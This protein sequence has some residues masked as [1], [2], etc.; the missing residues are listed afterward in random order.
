MRM[1]GFA[2]PD[3]QQLTR[4]A[5]W[6]K[7]SHRPAKQDEARCRIKALLTPVSG[8]SSVE[9]CQS[10]RCNLMID[11]WWDDIFTITTTTMTTS[12]V[13]QIIPMSES[14]PWGSDPLLQIANMPSPCTCR[15]RILIV[16]VKPSLTQVSNACIPSYMRGYFGSGKGKG[17]VACDAGFTGHIWRGS[18]KVFV[19]VRSR[20]NRISQGA[21]LISFATQHI[22]FSVYMNSKCRGSWSF[23]Y[24]HVVLVLAGVFCWP[25]HRY[26]HSVTSC[27]TKSRQSI[28]KL[29]PF[30]STGVFSLARFY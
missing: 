9:P 2:T 29:F 18:Q 1:D 27:R 26:Q 19:L 7:I 21:G 25:R 24:L 8:I 15:V 28:F 3:Y 10:A 20:V 14:D 30:R 12:T 22:Y 17:G 13:I 16:L 11:D 5:S 4:D 23:S 6:S